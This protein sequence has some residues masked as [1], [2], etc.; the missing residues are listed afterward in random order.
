MIR[1]GEATVSR[2]LTDLIRAPHAAGRGIS[3]VVRPFGAAWGSPEG[4]HHNGR[5]CGDRLAVRLR[6][7]AAWVVGSMVARASR[8]CGWRSVDGFC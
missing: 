6:T 3:I 2:S 7:G 8:P 4:L 1:E 5:Y